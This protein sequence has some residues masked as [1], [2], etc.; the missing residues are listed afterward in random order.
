MNEKIDQVRRRFKYPKFPATSRNE[1]DKLKDFYY[2]ARLAIGHA[3]RS[4]D[5]LGRWPAASGG[6]AP[7]RSGSRDMF[8]PEQL[9]AVRWFILR[10]DKRPALLLCQ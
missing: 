7:E 5:L 3:A 2:G 10:P 6:L 1:L 8:L 4:A 9:K